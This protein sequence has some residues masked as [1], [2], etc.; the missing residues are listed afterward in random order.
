MNKYINKYNQQDKS[1]LFSV[2]VALVPLWVRSLTIVLCPQWVCLQVK[3]LRWFW[4]ADFRILRRSR[5]KAIQ[6]Q[7]ALSWE[8]NRG[9]IGP[10]R[11]NW[12]T[13]WL[14]FYLDSLVSIHLLG[15]LL[16]VGLHKNCELKLNLWWWLGKG[17]NSF[18]Q[19]EFTSFTI[20]Q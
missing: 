17:Q 5:F 7:A 9:L 16:C 20:F 15:G 14:I 2:G 13:D 19:Q 1:L 11:Y 4:R 3:Q 10:Q 12:Q 8:T 18:W 6:P